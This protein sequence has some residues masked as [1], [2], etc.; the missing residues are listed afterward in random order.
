MTTENYSFPRGFVWGSATA[1]YQIEGAWKTDGKGLSIWDTFSHTPGKI[2]NGDT[3]D[4]ACDHYHR[5]AEDFLLMKQMGLKAYRF[6]ISWPRVLPHGRGT[7]S[8]KGLDYYDR[9]V[10]SLLALGIEPYI[11]LFHWD[12]PQSMHDIGGWLNRDVMGYFSDYAALMVRRLGDRVQHWMT[13]NEPSVVAVHGY[14]TGDHAPGIQ[15]QKTALQVGHNLLVAHGMATQAIRGVEPNAK[16]G[17]ALALSPVEPPSDKESDQLAADIRWKTDGAVMLDALFKA[18]YP[19]E[20]MKA[21]EKDLPEF[22]PQ[23]FVTISQRM[24]FLGINY[25][26]RTVFGGMGEVTKVP[27]S[28]YTEMGWEVCAEALGR[29][30]VKINREYHLPPIFI[31]EN[32]AALPDHL[33]GEHVHDAR[34]IKYIHDHLVEIRRAM[35]LGV[36][37]KG[38]FVWSLMDNFEWAYG[39]SK[40]FGLIYVDHETQKRVV[41]DSGYWYEKVARRNEVH[42]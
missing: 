4:V 2:E 34:R 26:F 27:G 39:Y 38:Y 17:I 12:L 23:D 31:T 32:G 25:Y 14:K 6:S 29:L 20:A 10:D 21:Y 3:G 1:A 24:D 18:C 19:P 36:R 15:D 5:F 41:K 35:R 40:R 11:T 16:V 37:V 42:R 28:E 8:A 22:K 7:V 30:L 33:V 13:I 9:M